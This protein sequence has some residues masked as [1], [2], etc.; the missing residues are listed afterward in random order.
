V[1]ELG[2]AL[3]ASSDGQTKAAS[4]KLARR[5]ADEIA[6][7]PADE[8]AA[9][10]I[11]PGQ[12]L[13]VLV[14]RLRGFAGP[15]APA[16]TRTL[17][18]ARAALE[19]RELPSALALLQ[20]ARRVAVA[21]GRFGEL[22]E[23]HELVRRLARLSD[24]RTRAGSE[25]LARKTAS[26]LRAAGQAVGLAS[27]GAT[28]ASRPMSAPRRSDGQTDSAGVLVTTAGAFVWVGL[29]LLGMAVKLFLVP[30][31]RG[32]GV[33]ALVWGLLF[34]AYLWWGSHQVGLREWKAELLGILAGLTI[35]LFVYLRGASLERPPADRPGVF[36]GRF[37][38]RRRRSTSTNT[39]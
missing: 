33:T 36:L 20:E 34:G 39:R 37:V 32:A 28:L 8:L 3:V 38:A 16:K 1:R 6:A 24:V 5:V 2:G 23:V 12:E 11:E 27:G 30:K 19:R 4:E 9:A 31:R 15:A 21:Q 22:L 29:A 14:S 7:F 25:R 18:D 35:A 13:A 10:G 17:S 26:D